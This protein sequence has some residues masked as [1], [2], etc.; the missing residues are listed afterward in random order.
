MASTITI[1]CPECDKQLRAPSDVLGKKIRCKGCG[2]TFA[3]RNSG[4]KAAAPKPAEKQTAKSAKGGKSAGKPNQDDDNDDTPYGMTEEYLGRRCPECANAMGDDD[5]IC[6]HCG[7]DT[8]TRVKARTRKVRHTTGFDMFL[9]L[10]PG[11]L[12]AILTLTLVGGCAYYWAAI[13]RETFGGEW[14]DFLG[15]LGMKVYTT[16]IALGICYK[17]GRFAFIRLVLHPK[18]P[19]IEE[20]TGPSE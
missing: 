11:I 10:L 8:M 15:S 1:T 3:A 4:G 6:L 13:D 5:R 17:A 9:W 20:K 19:E 12:Y 2:A 7:Y 18:P 14:Y 16:V